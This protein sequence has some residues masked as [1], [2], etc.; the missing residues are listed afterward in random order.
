M[1][2]VPAST[3]PQLESN[4]HILVV[5]DDLEIRSLLARYLSEQ[6]FEVSTAESGSKMSHA[7]AR[8][9]HDLVLLD[10]MLQDSSGLD[11]CRSLRSVSS[12]PVILLTARSEEVDRIVGLELGADDYVVKPFNPRELLARIR[13]VLRRSTPAPAVDLAVRWFRGPERHPA[14]FRL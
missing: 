11:L 12:T 4:A 2:S 6:G 3:T 1:P 9:P 5:D 7:L 13:A 8:R 10:V 14:R